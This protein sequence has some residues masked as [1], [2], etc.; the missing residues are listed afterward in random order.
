MRG[1]MISP[2]STRSP[3]E[4][5]SV[6]DVCG[7]RVVVTPYARLTS[8]CTAASGARRTPATC[9]RARRRS[10]GMIVLPETSIVRAP[11]G[12]VTFP[13]APTP[14]MRL[15]FTTMSPLR[16]H[17]VALHVMIRAP[18][19]TTVPRGLSFGDDDVHIVRVGS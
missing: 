13:C 4:I 17:L 12:M 2:V 15:F 10:P 9:A 3:Y 8:T 7:S 19:S 14:T 5:T 18:R 6:V 1:P 16:N 11:A